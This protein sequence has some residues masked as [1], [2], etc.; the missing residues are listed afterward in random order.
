[1]SG[2][3][4]FVFFLLVLHRVFVPFSLPSCVVGIFSPAFAGVSIFC[5]FVAFFVFREIVL[6]AISFVFLA[7][8]VHACLVFV[9]YCL[10]LL[11]FRISFVF[12]MFSISVSATWLAVTFYEF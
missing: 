3:W 2:V 11:L 7:L 1:M 8:F 12:P 4:R 6:Y 10:F 5:I 9:C